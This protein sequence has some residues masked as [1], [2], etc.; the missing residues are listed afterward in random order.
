MNEIESILREQLGEA[1]SAT[2]S[3]RLS[4][5]LQLI[6]DWNRRVDLVAPAETAELVERH[7]V[8]SF[9]AWRTLVDWGAELSGN[10]L[11]VGSGAGLPGIVWAIAAAEAG[12]ETVIHLLE[13]RDKRV[14]FLKE[15]RRR[16]ELSS[17]QVHQQ[18]LEDFFD[19]HPQQFS[20]TVCRALGEPELFLQGSRAV[21]R[22]G[23]I[24]IFMA[25]PEQRFDET[26]AIVLPYSLP[27]SG[28]GRGLAVFS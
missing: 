17:L 1:V 8:D 12:T 27:K 3:S 25:G 21:L 7:L 5:Y 10:I 6:I 28:A 11:D 2:T 9:L 18:R 13:P 23:G 24:A 20:A 4:A 22:A 26:P 16:L 19:N 14:Q 15:A